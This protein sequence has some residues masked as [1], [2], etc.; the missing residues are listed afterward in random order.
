MAHID[1]V[2]EGNTD[3]IKIA[4]TGAIVFPKTGSLVPLIRGSHNSV[5]YAFRAPV[6]VRGHD[7][8]NCTRVEIHYTNI[9]VRS[10]QRSKGVYLVD[11]MEV[12][13]ERYLNFSWLVSGNATKYKGSLEFTIFFICA[14]QDEGVEYCWPTSIDNTLIVHGSVSH[15]L[16]ILEDTP[17]DLLEQWRDGMVDEVHSLVQE[18]VDN[19]VKQA[20]TE[21]MDAEAEVVSFTAEA[22]DWVK[23]S[24]EYTQEFF[25]D[26]VGAGMMVDVLPNDDLLRF[27]E[28][29]GGKLIRVK[30]DAGSLTFCMFCSDT[31][32]EI[33]TD[34]TVQLKVHKVTSEEGLIICGSGVSVGDSAQGILEKLKT[35]DGKG[36]GLDADTLDGLQSA[37]M[38]KNGTALEFPKGCDFLEQY[39][40]FV[41]ADGVAGSTG[42]KTH[43]TAA[44]SGRD[45]LN[46]PERL[47]NKMFSGIFLHTGGSPAPVF[48]WAE[49]ENTIYVAYLNSAS[50]ELNWQAM[51]TQLYQTYA[52]LNAESWV[53][54]EEQG[55][56]ELS[57][58]DANIS[59][60]DRPKID[61]SVP[62]QI[63]AVEYAQIS[64]AFSLI[65]SCYAQ[66]G[67]VIF[68]SY[69][70]KPSVTITVNMEV[71]KA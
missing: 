35:V 38:M 41:A 62:E 42:I 2:V 20:A 12:Y 14:D 53:F 70:G 18:E 9:D 21:L 71:R 61:L 4:Y 25:I 64:E 68:K 22:A 51:G 34:V 55:A 66:D 27:I 11:D 69:E 17:P 63:T 16:E 37:E 15:D 67:T 31:S 39:K 33:A 43:R 50:T 46:V 29:S 23:G 7:M 52:V 44:F 60:N 49:G 56:Y 54:N 26:G 3:P 30:N 58:A 48:I 28:S 59:A 13:E 45:V 10:K 65:S 6:T 24:A 1:H 5:R 36:S 47:Q 32:K 8:K 40:T 57:A 19:Q